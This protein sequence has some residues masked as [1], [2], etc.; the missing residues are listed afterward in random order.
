MANEKDVMKAAN[1]DREAFIRII[2]D[3]RLTLY[4]ISKTKLYSDHDC[5]DAIQETILKA[6]KSIHALRKAKYFK[7]WIIRILLNEC[8]NLLRSRQKHQY[9]E[10]KDDNHFAKTNPN[11]SLTLEIQELLYEL[12]EELR[13]P[14]SSLLS[15]IL[16]TFQSRK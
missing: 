16:K 13:L 8:N 3:C 2:N 14:F 10:K 9:V 5:A 12:T 7:S 6:Y 11:L 1:G 15:F 4:R